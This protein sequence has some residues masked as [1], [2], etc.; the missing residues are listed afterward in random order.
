MRTNWHRVFLTIV[1]IV[2]GTSAIVLIASLVHGGRAFLI[3]ANQK[4][5]KNNKDW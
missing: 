4:I 2:I 5:S 3:H 1:G